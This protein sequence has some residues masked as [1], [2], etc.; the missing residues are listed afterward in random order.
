[1]FPRAPGHVQVN[2][3]TI[4]PETQ[5]DKESE[6]RRKKREFIAKLEKRK[7]ERQKQT[8]AERK[9]EEEW[10]EKVN[11]EA[12]IVSESNETF[13]QCLTENDQHLEDTERMTELSKEWKNEK[14]DGQEQEQ[15]EDTERRTE[16]SKE[17]KNENEN[18][19]E[20]EQSDKRK[21]EQNSKRCGHA[22]FLIPY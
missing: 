12:P 18:G 15:S 19:Q 20:Q 7:R 1:M 6:K 22:P 21:Q 5:E 3:V 13:R 4:K 16:L 14:E 2:S 11:S 8:E 17:R 10:S 9:D